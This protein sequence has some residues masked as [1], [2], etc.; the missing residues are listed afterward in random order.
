MKLWH[1]LLLVVMLSVSVAL[2]AT[3]PTL[4]AYLA[5]VEEEIGK[6]LDR[7]ESGAPSRERNMVRTI[8]RAHSHELVASVVKPHTMHYNWGLFSFFETTAL[9]AHIEI[10]GIGGHFIPIKGMDEAAVRFGRLAF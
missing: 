9:D 2:A 10:L 7:Y 1:L 3:N 5:F 4:D 8:F 6:A